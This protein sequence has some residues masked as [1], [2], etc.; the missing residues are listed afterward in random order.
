MPEEYS[1]VRY[2]E[3]L[4]KL[5]TRLEA[6]YPSNNIKFKKLLHDDDYRLKVLTRAR[7]VPD[8]DIHRVLRQ[9][10]SYQSNTQLDHQELDADILTSRP[11]RT[12]TQRIAAN[13]WSFALL[14]ALIINVPL[15]VIMLTDEDQTTI[16]ERSKSETAIAELEQSRG[17]HSQSDQSVN[18]NAAD[19]IITEVILNIRGSNTLGDAIT[20]RLA[21]EYLTFMGAKQTSMTSVE[22]ENRTVIQGVFG[23]NLIREIHVEAKGS[24]TSFVALAEG[25]AQIGMSSRRVRLEEITQL[26]PHDDSLRSLAHEHVMGLDGIAVVVHADNPVKQ[27]TTDEL[28]NVFSGEITNWQELGGENRLIQ[29]HARDSAS[30]TFDTFN[31]LVLKR[32]GRS[33]SAAAL[34]YQSNSDLSDAVSEDSGGI[35]FSG[36]GAVRQARVIAVASNSSAVAVYPTPFTIKTEDYPLSRRLYLYTTPETT[37][38]SHVTDFINFAFSRTGQRLVDDSGFVSLEISSERVQEIASAPDEY[39]ELT[40]SASRLSVNFRFRSGSDELDYKSVH[41]LNRVVRY[42]DRAGLDGLTI[43]GFTDDV[44]DEDVNI[45]LS[46][47]RARI[48]SDELRQRGVDSIRIIGMG[49]RMPVSSNLTDTGRIKNRRTEIWVDDT[50]D[51]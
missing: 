37:S 42:L 27:L 21:V 28:A 15:L 24:S 10:W 19:H 38:Q 26:F 16:V 32:H 46:I 6:L 48:V 50:G 5:K 7:K 25:S 30:G 31:S 20:P 34:R 12:L 18:P 11:A 36:L 51:A 41:D 44:G 47:A 3:Y 22:G 9:I 1:H 4:W 17:E 14:V 33:L 45:R 49:E 43:V 39:R 13:R 29:L 8:D 40:Q 35:G 2:V 23:N